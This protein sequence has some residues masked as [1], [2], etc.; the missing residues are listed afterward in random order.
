MIVMPANSTGWFWHCL[1]RETGKLGHLYSPRAQRGPWPWFPYALD[2]GAFSCWDKKSNT[3]DAAKWAAMENSWRQ[4]L[5]WAQAAPLKALWAI[6]PDVPGNGP[7]T[8]EQWARFAPEV[9]AAGIPLAVAVQDG[10]T[11]E[12]VRALNPLPAVVAIGGSDEFKWGTVAMWA[13]E[14]PRVHLLRCNSPTRLEE[15]TEL[16]IESTDGTGWCRGDR[17]QTSGLEEWCRKYTDTAPR[18]YHPLAP[19]VCRQAACSRQI[20][21]A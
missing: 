15:L 9:V 12:M 10:M 17:K 6:V 11:P 8:I 1:A 13:K 14:F 20:T 16:R 19:H 2:N 18:K 4:L 7:A 21:F 5:F 3:F